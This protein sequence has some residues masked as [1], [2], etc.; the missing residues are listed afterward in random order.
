MHHLRREGTIWTVLRVH[1]FTCI[2]P[3]HVAIWSVTNDWSW[4]TARLL[5]LW[6]DLVIW[7]F[8]FS[9][10]ATQ[11]CLLINDKID[12]AC[13]VWSKL[14]K[15]DVLRDTRER[16]MLAEEGSLE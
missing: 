6:T 13:A 12:R 11:K 10:N 5:W 16:V 7:V 9:L 2:C 3:H 8:C 1:R 4:L 15:D 14:A